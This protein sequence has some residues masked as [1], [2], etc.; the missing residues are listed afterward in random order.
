MDNI[1]LF[2]FVICLIFFLCLYY[3]NLISS[4][5]NINLFVFYIILIVLL[6]V[7]LKFIQSINK[8]Q[9]YNI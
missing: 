3:G 1:A 4:W 7:F 6:I 8:Q 9:I 2:Q 5:L